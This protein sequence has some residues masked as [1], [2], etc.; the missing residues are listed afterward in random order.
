MIDIFVD[1]KKT[2]NR[3]E[4]RICCPFCVDR[5]F[6]VDKKYHLYVN[7]EFGIF[8]CFRCGESGRV[9]KLKRKLNFGFL[10]VSKREKSIE[11]SVSRKVVST[12]VDYLD[13]FSESFIAKVARTYW[14]RRGLTLEQAKKYNIKINKTRLS[15]VIP[16]FDENS[17]FV[18]NI[19]RM[20]FDDNF[21]YYIEKGVEKSK[22]LYNLN[23][24]KILDTI[25]IV[26]GVFDVFAVDNAVALMGKFIS[27]EQL[28]KLRNTNIKKVIV[29]LDSDARIESYRL[30]N[31]LLPFFEVGRVDFGKSGFKDVSEMRQKIGLEKT[32]CWLKENT[33]A[34]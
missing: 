29:M 17:N 22:Y 26:E 23:N 32:L 10:N 34:I 5:G 27:D 3:Y 6:S 14:V 2:G 4:I 7:T 8:H 16:V 20:I 18:F 19:E 25:Y 13:F 33:M 12:D 30:V 31:K 11:S 24:V 21:K 28:K 1:Y 9:E 15:I